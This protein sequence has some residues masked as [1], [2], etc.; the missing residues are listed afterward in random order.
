MAA[1]E[2]FNTAKDWQERGFRLRTPPLILCGYDAA[3]GG[4]DRDALVMLQREEHQKGETWDPDF[5][6]L[7][8]YRLLMAYRM[9]PDFEF[10]DKLAMLLRLNIQLNNWRGRGRIHDHVF[11]IETNGVGYAMASSLGTKIGHKVIKY[12]TVST[13]SE[14]RVVQK[15]ISMPRLA[16]LDHMR[17]LLET[18]AFK[19]AKDAT[20]NK[21]FAREVNSFVWHQKNAPAAIAGQHDDLVMAACGAVWIGSR[22]IPPIL[23]AEKFRKRAGR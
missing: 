8:M 22:I 14:D 10:P 18:H 7:T 1:F 21:D 13:L 3:G 4:D 12:T 19:V 2:A 16:A 20:G 17:V 23:K 15:N 5:A 9:P 6:V 11:C